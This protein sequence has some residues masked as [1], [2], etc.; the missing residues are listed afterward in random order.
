MD[1]KLT[2]VG[3]DETILLGNEFQKLIIKEVSKLIC[4]MGQNM[5]II[6]KSVKLIQKRPSRT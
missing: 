1:L 5:L 4:S 2:A 3:D 6:K